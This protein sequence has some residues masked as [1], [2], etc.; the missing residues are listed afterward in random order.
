ML[1]R[2]IRYMQSQAN[3]NFTRLGDEARR[4]DLLLPSVA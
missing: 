2:L 1:A 3:V 4:R